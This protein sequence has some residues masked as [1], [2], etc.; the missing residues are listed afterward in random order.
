[1]AGSL[2][3]TAAVICGPLLAAWASSSCTD[4]SGGDAD[5]LLNGT[6]DMSNANPEVALSSLGTG[7]VVGTTST[8]YMTTPGPE[9]KGIIFFDNQM[10]YTAVEKRAEQIYCAL[11]RNDDIL[12]KPVL[13][14][15]S[16]DALETICQA[17]GNSRGE[18]IMEKLELYEKLLEE[19]S[20]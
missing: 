3:G 2:E 6:S 16:Q 7:A 15:D 11:H 4:A 12:K 13:I 20:H 1:M 8:S 14:A 5:A 17:F 18:S 9:P 19:L 10:P